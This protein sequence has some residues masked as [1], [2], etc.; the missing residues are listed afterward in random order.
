MPLLCLSLFRGTAIPVLFSLPAVHS[1]AKLAARSH[2]HPC[3][4]E[5]SAQL[6]VL[7]V[8]ALSFSAVFRP[9]F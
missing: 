6:C 3:H 9:A 5:F 2:A 1:S 8:S 4:A 7:G